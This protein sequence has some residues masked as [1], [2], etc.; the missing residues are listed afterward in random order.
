MG[1]PRD[2][3]GSLDLRDDYLKSEPTPLMFSFANDD[4]RNK[5][6]L[7]FGDSMWSKPLSFETVAA[8][9][10]VINEAG[11]GRFQVHTGLSYV[12]GLGKVRQSSAG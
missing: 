4:R 12:E 3:A 1:Q 8:D 5:C 6:L 2:A 9:M 10:E 7:K 11:A